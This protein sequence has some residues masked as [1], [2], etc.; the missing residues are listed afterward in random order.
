MVDGSTHIIHTNTHTNSLTTSATSRSKIQ[1][2]EEEEEEKVQNNCEGIESSTSVL[3]AGANTTTELKSICHAANA[4]AANANAAN[5]SGS[6]LQ[7]SGDA[8]DRSI[9]ILSAVPART[10]L[11]WLR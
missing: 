9:P 1:I 7:Q 2:Q 4:N 6:C 3:S 10:N 8:S 5:A 11:K